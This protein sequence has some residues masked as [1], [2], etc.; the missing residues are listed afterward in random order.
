MVTNL[1]E[2]FRKKIGNLAGPSSIP[3]FH[4][5]HCTMPFSLSIGESLEIQ[6]SN[7]CRSRTQHV[8]RNILGYWHK[9]KDPH[10]LDFLEAWNFIVLLKNTYVLRIEFIKFLEKEMSQ[11]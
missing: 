7:R 9:L 3:C 8:A 11:Y 6:K 2:H 10:L 4:F 1:F 5:L